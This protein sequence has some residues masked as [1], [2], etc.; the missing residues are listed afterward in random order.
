MTTHAVATTEEG[1]ELAKRY[2][3]GQ[4]ADALVITVGV[5][6]P[7]HVA[8]ALASVRK[9]GTVVVTAVGEHSRIVFRSRSPTSP[10]P[11][12]ACRAASS[13]RRT[14]RGTSIGC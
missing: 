14:A 10:S 2:T 5:L 12:S 11:R 9:A 3:D 13:A 6:E 4:G 1:A 8:Q 7:E